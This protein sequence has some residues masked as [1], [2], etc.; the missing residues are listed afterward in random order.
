M[1]KAKQFPISATPNEFSEALSE[2]R[3]NVLMT[4]RGFCRIWAFWR[5]ASH[6]HVGN[7]LIGSN[8]RRS[9][10]MFIYVD[11]LETCSRPSCS[12][13]SDDVRLS[14]FGEPISWELFF[15]SPS[16]ERLKFWIWVEWASQFDERA[17]RGAVARE[18]QSHC[19][20]A[21]G[22]NG[23]GSDARDAEDSG[24]TLQD[25]A[26]SPQIHYVACS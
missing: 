18:T 17:W 25:V 15:D 13:V 4:W 23:T 8:F 1:P 22:G 14:W 10:T 26:G 2:N 16:R 19:T 3:N 6:V 5:W 9:A 7:L 20:G 21:P 11:V 12:T 24:K